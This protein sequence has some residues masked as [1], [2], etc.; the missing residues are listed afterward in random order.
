M[1]K[2]STKWRDF[3]FATASPKE[4]KTNQNTVLQPKSD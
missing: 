1:E 2:A 4:I 3:S